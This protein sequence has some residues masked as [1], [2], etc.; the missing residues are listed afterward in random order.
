MT[1]QDCSL[2]GTSPGRGAAPST[3]FVAAA[4]AKNFGNAAN[5]QK[6]MQGVSTVKNAF[7]SVTQPGCLPAATVK[8]G[9]SALV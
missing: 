6:L 3:V 1:D 5:S 4:E 9:F 8:Q 2:S 7:G